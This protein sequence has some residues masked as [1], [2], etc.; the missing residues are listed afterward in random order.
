MRS[1]LLNVDRLHEIQQSRLGF[2]R[3]FAVS[4]SRR[5]LALDEKFQRDVAT[6]QEDRVKCAGTWDR[7]E[8]RIERE[9]IQVGLC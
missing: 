2:A 9:H 5:L 6:L 4:L 8:F 7:Q 1:H 3:A